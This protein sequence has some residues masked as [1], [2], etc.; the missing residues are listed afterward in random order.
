MLVSREFAYFLFFCDKI[1][2]IVTLTKSRLVPTIVVILSQ[3][4]QHFK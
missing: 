3:L 4:P 2:F 1:N